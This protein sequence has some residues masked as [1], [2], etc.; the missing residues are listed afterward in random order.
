MRLSELLRQED[1]LVP[2]EA[3][4]KW[5]AI[6]RL[7]AHLVKC[8]RIPEDARGEL[9]ELVLARER[10]M[11]TGMEHGIAIPHAAVDALDEL[12]ACMGVVQS[13]EGLAFEA[14]DARPSYLV[15]VLLIPRAQKLLHIRTLADVARVLRQESVRQGLLSAPNSQGAWKVLDEAEAD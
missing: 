13:P 10:S 8:G 6:A 14:I 15:V 9:L 4:D 5:D 3:V 1:L 12:V 11:S 7:V 2:L